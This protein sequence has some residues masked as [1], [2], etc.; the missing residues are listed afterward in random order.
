MLL[1]AARRGDAVTRPDVLALAL[2]GDAVVLHSDA[3]T[4]EPEPRQ[5]SSARR[6][7][8][9]SVPELDADTCDTLLLLVS[10]LVTNAVVHARTELEVAVTVTADDVVVAVHDLDLG[11]REQRG[12]E[13]DGGRGLGLVRSLAADSGMLAHDGGGKS[14]WFRLHRGDAA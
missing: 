13:R 6:F 11:R 14:A 3:L 9:R 2:P 5:V 12:G 1:Q 4:L 7:V 10:E 8:A